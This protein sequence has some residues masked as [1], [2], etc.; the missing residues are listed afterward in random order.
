MKY[1]MFVEGIATSR[2]ISI[3]FGSMCAMVAVTFHSKFSILKF[4]NN[5]FNLLNY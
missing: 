4:L 5:F 3:A 2:G 1:I